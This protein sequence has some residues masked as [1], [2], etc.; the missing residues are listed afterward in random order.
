MSGK[1][2]EREHP[3]HP[4]LRPESRDPALYSPEEDD[5]YGGHHLY[6]IND[7]FLSRMRSSMS[8]DHTRPHSDLNQPL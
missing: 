5:D 8:N 1:G 7:P 2:K 4:G 3:R 6:A